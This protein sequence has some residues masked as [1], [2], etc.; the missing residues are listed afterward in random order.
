MVGTFSA[1]SR[2]HGKGKSEPIACSAAHDWVIIATPATIDT[3]PTDTPLMDTLEAEFAAALALQR[4]GELAAAEAAYRRLLERHGAVPD[5]EHMLGLALHAQGRSDESLAWFERAESQRTGATLWSNHAAALLALGRGN[6]AAAL[7]RQATRAAPE[8]VGSWL[9]LGLACEIERDYGEAMTALAT[10]LRLAPGHEAAMR[11]L[12]RCQL[13]TGDPAAALRILSAVP[14]HK[15]A[16]ADLLRCEAWVDSANFAPAAALLQRL[17]AVESVRKEA[18]LLQAKIATEQ[19]SGNAALDLYR[20]VMQFDPE[21]RAAIVR[22]ALIHINRAETETGLEQMRGWLRTHPQDQSAASTYL[23]ACDYSERFDPPALLA[24]H[25]RLRPQPASAEPWPGNWKPASTQRKLRIGWVSSAFSVGPIEIFFADVVRAFADVAPDIEHVLYAIGGESTSAPAA[26]AWAKN[27]R[28][29]SRLS[30]RNALQAIRSD[31]LDIL[32]DMVGRAAGNRLAIFAA[33]AAPLQVGWHDQFYPSGIEA[34]DYLVTDRWLSPPGAEAD[35]SEKL[36]R[37]PHGR[38]A[39]SPPPA[40]EPVPEGVMSRRFI[41]LN[42]FSKINPAVVAV[43]AEVLRALPDWTMLLKARG[44]EDADLG[45]LIRGR[46]AD[47]GVAGERI[48]I[49]GGGSYA[50]AMQAYNGAA[51]ALDPFPFTGCS[52]T[53]D[54]L[55]MGLPVITWPRQTIASRQSVALLEAAGKGAWIAKDAA[56]YVAIAAKL[57][58]DVDG[59]SDWRMQAREV[60]R[61]AF[62]DPTRLAREL[63][64]A[65]RAVALPRA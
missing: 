5:A 55:W 57:A 63:L 29:L 32:V 6:E 60:L 34:M 53:C 10:A 54:A 3:L 19:G 27:V 26:A 37:L 39:Y 33:R 12:A 59:R 51:I 56:D 46:F 31:N 40:G 1:K 16:A 45:F 24:E 28:D 22:A 50:Q 18:L 44:G 47:H 11:A 7:C 17:T 61:P 13:R 48:I 14:E 8:H 43:W 62:C 58:A 9:N 30:D 64:Q 38:M 41:S 4:R 52:T 49:E 25:Q 35:F 42:R 15:D 20:Q 65:L 23:V 36:L 2:P 21:N